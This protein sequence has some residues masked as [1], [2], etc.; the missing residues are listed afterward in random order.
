MICNCQN[1]QLTITTDLSDCPNN[2][3]RTKQKTDIKI[4]SLKIL[5]THNTKQL[6]HLNK[7]N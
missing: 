3:Q 1:K 5:T 4:T 2:G 6:Y 7:F